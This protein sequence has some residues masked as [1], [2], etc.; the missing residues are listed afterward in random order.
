[1]ANFLQMNIGEK[2]VKYPVKKQINLL[3]FETEK[4]HSKDILSIILIVL[5]LVAFAKFGVYDQFMKLQAAQREYGI[6]Q[7]Q[8][9]EL[10]QGNAT[11]EDIKKEYDKVTEW[12]MTEEEKATID[13]MDVLKMLEDDL[14]PYVS[15]V[16][17]SVAGTTVTVQTG[18]TT[19]ETVAEFLLRLQNDKRNRTAT[20]TT[21]STAG[22]GTVVATIIIDFAGG[23][24]EVQEEKKTEEDINE[25]VEEKNTE[26]TED[27]N[28]KEVISETAGG[29]AD[30]ES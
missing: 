5:C 3:R 18:E 12:Y 16:N 25:E 8:L 27:E 23:K 9:I 4:S 6:A 21:T 30:A 29:D 2:K 11:Y 19:L 13:K 26:E 20:V 7:D 22:S 15:V 10:R 1:M 17:V 28:Q 14:M 24:E